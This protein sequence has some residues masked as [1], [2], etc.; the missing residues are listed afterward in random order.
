[1]LKKADLVLESALERS[2][3]ERLALKKSAPERWLAWRLDDASDVSI[4]RRTNG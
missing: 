1:M 3:P 2:A 4:E